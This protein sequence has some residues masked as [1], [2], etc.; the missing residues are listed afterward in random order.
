MSFNAKNLTLRFIFL[1][2]TI[3]QAEN[4][5]MPLKH[6]QKYVVGLALEYPGVGEEKK[7]MLKKAFKA[8]VET[9]ERL[10]VEHGEVTYMR[11]SKNKEDK[12]EEEEPEQ[13]VVEKE[14][15]KMRKK[16]KE[17]KDKA[18]REEDV[19]EVVAAVEEMGEKETKKDK[20]RKRKI[21]SAKW[22]VQS[23]EEAPSKKRALKK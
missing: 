10:A 6:L 15:E 13:E 1:M 8:A 20:K 22:E 5:K 7:K 4:K 2:S 16:K 14:D 21:R 11:R 12:Q 17:K 3:T 19:A 18:E 9:H 23:V